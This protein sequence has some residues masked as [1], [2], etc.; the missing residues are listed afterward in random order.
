[1]LDHVAIS[2]SDVDT[3]VSWYVKNCKAIVLHKDETWAML[4]VGS[5]KLAL[6]V[7][8]QHPP[9]I[10]FRV[11]SLEEIPCEKEDIGIHRDGSKYLYAR[12]PDENVIEWIYYGDSVD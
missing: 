12:D 3:S 6:T 2:V 1:M 4:S 5:T 11:D 8:S 7:K 10:A 9:H